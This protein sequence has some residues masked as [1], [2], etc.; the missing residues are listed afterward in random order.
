MIGQ[1][2]LELIPS[3]AVLVNVSRGA[4][5]DSEAL[6]ARLKRGDIVAG[7]DVFDPEPIPPDS[8]IIGLRNVFLSPHIAGGNRYRS[9]ALPDTDGRRTGAI[10]PRPRD[11]LRPDAPVAG[12]SAG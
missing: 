1:R 12:Q 7:L 6:I 3:G 9:N 8:E 4:I 10:L 2:E 5:I 11:P